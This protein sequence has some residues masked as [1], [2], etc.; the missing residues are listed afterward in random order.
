MDTG[1]QSS[2][3]AKSYVVQFWSKEHQLQSL[4]L[5]SGEEVQLLFHPGLQ[6][7]REAV[8]L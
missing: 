4:W 1:L 6:M 2:W 3:Q 8:I 7:M 5:L